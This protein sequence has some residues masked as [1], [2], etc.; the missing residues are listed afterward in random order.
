MAW[1]T[2][3]TVVADFTTRG[4]SGAV[5][6][7]SLPTGVLVLNGTDNGATVTVTNKATGSYKFSVVL[8]T[9]AEGDLLQVRINAVVDSV[10]DNGIVW[11]G[12]TSYSLP[13]AL[14]DDIANEGLPTISKLLKYV[15][16]IT[17]SDAAIATDN[18]AERTEINADGGSGGGNWDNSNIQALQ[19]LSGIS[20]NLLAVLNDTGGTDGVK[21][22][23]SADVYHADIDFTRDQSN[24]QDEYTVKWLKNGIPQST[25]TGATIQVVSRDGSDLIASTAMTDVGGGLLTYDATG[26]ERQTQ[27]EAVEVV[28]TATVNAATRTFSRLLG[29]DST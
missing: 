7:D 16:L 29:R 8:P 1:R 13:Y 10:T 25:V 27:G 24:T 19:S 22:A 15:Q 20:G 14:P 23:S 4:A 21:L 2:G 6:A 11:A 12:R 3:E 5:N 9:T 26:A 28:V 17:R 18:A